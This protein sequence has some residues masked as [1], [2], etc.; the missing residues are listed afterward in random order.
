MR[1]DAVIDR[2]RNERA[3]FR[4]RRRVSWEDLFEILRF[5]RFGMSFLAPHGYRERRLA[6]MPRKGAPSMKRYWR[7]CED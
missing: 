1:Y 3:E 2:D 6:P 5:Q 4:E 7:T